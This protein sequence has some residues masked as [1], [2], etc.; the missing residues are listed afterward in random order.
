MSKI[1]MIFMLLLAPIS[2]QGGNFGFSLGAGLQYSGVLG[3]QF[4]FRQKNI[5]YHLSVG[6]P[7]YSL[8]LEKSFSRYNNHSVG[9]VAGEMFM[10]FAKENAKYSF[11]TYNYHFSGFS[12]SG[13]VIGGGLG[14]YKEGAASWGDDDDPKAKTTYTVDV[15]YKF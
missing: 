11:A 12:N 4:S 6:V 15:G 8:G 13:W 1:I 2:S 3:T 9:L 7:G 10:L 5:K 14:L